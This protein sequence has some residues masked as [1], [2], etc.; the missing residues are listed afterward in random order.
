M[1]A[2]PERSIRRYEP[3]RD[4]ES[5]SLKLRLIVMNFLQFFVWGAW[6]ITIARHKVI[7]EARAVARSPVRVPR[8]PVT[9]EDSSVTGAVPGPETTVPEQLDRAG[10]SVQLGRYLAQLAIREQECLRLRYAEELPGEQISQA[11]RCSASGARTLQY[12][13]VKR[14]SGLLAD[15]G[16]VSSA[17]FVATCDGSLVET[18]DAIAERRRLSAQ[19][20]VRACIEG[21]RSD[22][23]A[24]T[25]SSHIPAREVA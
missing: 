7:D 8:T 19:L 22:R 23:T 18:R 9:S 2:A 15:D 6:L 24:W 5:M 17:G 3:T 1:T 20:A 21:D 25:A 14:L 13:A 12:R 16:H 11:L 10:V 4:A